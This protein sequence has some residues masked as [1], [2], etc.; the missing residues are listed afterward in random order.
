MTTF[1]HFYYNVQC[2]FSNSSCFSVSVTWI[3]IHCRWQVNGIYISMPLPAY[4]L[5]LADCSPA[6]SSLRW[7]RACGPWPCP[8]EVRRPARWLWWWRH[9]RVAHFLAASLRYSFVVF[10]LLFFVSLKKKILSTPQSSHLLNW[11]DNTYLLEFL[12]RWRDILFNMLSTEKMQ[13]PSPFFV[14]RKRG[15]STFATMEYLLCF[16]AVCISRETT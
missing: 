7:G 16:Y 8:G 5:Q 11:N 2:F 9:C 15:G 1:W 6:S 12:S 10:F 14:L 13:L 3:F 4:K